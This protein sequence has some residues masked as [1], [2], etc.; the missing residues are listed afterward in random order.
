MAP[1][2]LNRIESLLRQRR[3]EL[4]RDYGV[5]EMG[6]FGSCARDEAT[7]DSDIDILVEFSRPVGFFKFLELE[8]QLSELLGAKVDLVT[9][10]ALK[11]RIGRNIL[12][13]VAML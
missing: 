7:D 2:S 13:E 6:I 4:A 11:P 8:E 5:A 10:A 1:P 3:D 9:K 12:N